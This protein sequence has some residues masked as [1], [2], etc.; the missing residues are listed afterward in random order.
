[1]IEL[2][3]ET[4]AGSNYDRFWVEANQRKLF[5]TREKTEA[6][7]NKLEEI[8]ARE[9]VDGPGKISLFETYV[10]EQ[11]Q[12]DAE[13]AAARAVEEEKKSKQVNIEDENWSKED[14]ANLTKGIVRFPP[15]TPQRWRVITEFC[16]RRN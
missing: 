4:L 15:G 2:C 11:T 3:T 14:I 12:T 6:C 13:R 9:D 16:G 8:K 10:A 1:M 5:Q 7:L